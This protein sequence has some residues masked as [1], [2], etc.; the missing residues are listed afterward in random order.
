M[1]KSSLCTNQSIPRTSEFTAKPDQKSPLRNKLSITQS[2]RLGG[3]CS[4]GK[5][6][7]QFY[8]GTIKQAQCLEIYKKMLP[9]AKKMFGEEDWT[10]MHDGALAHTAKS[11]NKWLEEEV[12]EY[13]LSG[14]YGEWPGNSPDCNWLEKCL[15]HYEC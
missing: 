5:L 15:G 11:V 12:P 4:K 13:I 1:K 10:F 8:K 6:P 9:A 7:L 14:Q 3:I 2:Q